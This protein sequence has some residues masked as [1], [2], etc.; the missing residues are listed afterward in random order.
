MAFCSE[1]GS[2]D[3]VPKCP[4]FVFWVGVPRRVCALACGISGI[5]AGLQAFVQQSAEHTR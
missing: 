3:A 2:A 1:L 4:R 5:S